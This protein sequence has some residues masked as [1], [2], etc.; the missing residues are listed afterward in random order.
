MSTILVVDD[1]ATM[2]SLFKLMLESAGYQVLSAGSAPDALALLRSL[3]KPPALILLDLMMPGMTGWDFREVQLEDPA[4]ADIP[5]VVLSAMN[6]L[7]TRAEDLG[8]SE[9]IQKPMPVMELLAVV[10][11]YC[12][13]P[14]G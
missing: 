10:A 5:V 6:D 11:R 8:I 4:L 12:P 2:R 13:S 9:A 7:P 3:D 1:D 14:R